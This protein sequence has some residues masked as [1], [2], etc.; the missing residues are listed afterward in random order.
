MALLGGALGIGM[1]LIGGY[2]EGG[3]VLNL[4]QYYILPALFPSLF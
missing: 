1:A 2:P 3:D 4:L